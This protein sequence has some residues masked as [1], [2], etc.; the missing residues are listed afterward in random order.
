MLI[1]PARGV[2]LDGSQKKMRQIWELLLNHEK[3][4][5]NFGNIT[6]GNSHQT[7]IDDLMQNDSRLIHAVFK[8]REA[9]KTCLAEI[10]E[11]DFGLSVVVSGLY[12]EVKALCE[13]ICLRP[14]TV[15]FS[16]GIHG[17]TDR[18]PEEGVL[19]ITTMCGHALVSPHLVSHMIGELEQGKTT[20]EAAAD[21]LS[22]GC[23]CGIFNSFRAEK[24]LRRLVKG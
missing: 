6:T 4:L 7:S 5:V 9:L 15:E 13:E 8:D 2:N 11:R 3:N 19:E 21:E 16:L 24:L 1:M 22:R 23:A 14:H 18:L 12:D 20:F 17:N 10:K